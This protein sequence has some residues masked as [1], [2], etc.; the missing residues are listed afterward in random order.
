MY[1]NG[2][3]HPEHNTTFRYQRRRTKMNGNNFTFVMSIQDIFSFYD[4]TKGET[5]QFYMYIYIIYVCVCIST[6]YIQVL[7]CT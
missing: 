3:L 2:E 5:I 1:N 6:L 4:L 7:I